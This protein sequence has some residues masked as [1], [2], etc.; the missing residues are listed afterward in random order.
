[1][2]SAVENGNNVQTP[3]QAKFVAY[4]VALLDPR[5]NANNDKL[6][7]GADVYGVEVTVP[8]LAARC[9]LGNL[10]PQHLGGDHTRAAIE[11]A[12]LVA[13]PP[14]SARLVTIRPD[15][16][17]L[18]S[19]AI[20]NMRQRGEPLSDEVLERVR[21]IA[22]SDTF[23]KGGWPGVRPMPS[24]D[25]RWPEGKPELDAMAKLG[26]DHK[27]SLA[28]RVRGIEEWIKTGAEPFAYDIA[29]E[30][31]RDELV[32]ALESGAVTVETRGSIAL[33][34]GNHRTLLDIGYRSA[35]IVIALNPA[36]QLHGGAPHAKYTIC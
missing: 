4:D 8:A 19:M 31:E 12:V 1:M 30:K 23:A 22:A 16:D 7:E 25:N 32:D 24:R 13:L 26:F 14:A 9:N 15:L 36:F 27:V 5:P 11:D 3:E 35:P 28:D 33:V 29:V 6:F 2:S 18:G 34:Q 17:S 21:K 20:L 10:D